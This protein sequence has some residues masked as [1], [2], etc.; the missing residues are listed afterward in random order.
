MTLL[1][2]T[3]D[4]FRL[5]GWRKLAVALLTT[6]LLPSLVAALALGLQ[7]LMGSQ[8]W[9]DGFLMFWALS[10]L[11][12]FSPV[13]SWFALLVAIPLVMVM[14]NRGWFG[15]I[16]ALMLGMI[17]GAALAFFVGNEAMVTFGAA[18]MAILR[19]LLARTCRKAFSAPEGLS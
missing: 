10:V 11:V 7:W 3:P 1:L 13:L 5:L 4:G 17:F 2:S 9:G 6:W 12:L 8:S 18:Q 15:W 19:G 16:P 14:M